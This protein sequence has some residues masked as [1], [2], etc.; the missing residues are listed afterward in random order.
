MLLSKG[1]YIY[2]RHLPKGRCFFLPIRLKIYIQIKSQIKKL[3]NVENTTII[4]IE[5]LIRVLGLGKIKCEKYGD[6]IINIIKF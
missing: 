2:G 6:D 1:Y 3:N 5:E 4:N